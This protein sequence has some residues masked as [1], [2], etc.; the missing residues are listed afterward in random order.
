MW[1]CAS[2]H[3]WTTDVE[4]INHPTNWLFH[5]S[6]IINHPVNLH[7]VQCTS[8]CDKPRA[9]LIAGNFRVRL[10]L[11]IIINYI[12]PIIPL[13]F[14]VILYGA[15]MHDHFTSPRFAPRRLVLNDFNSI[16]LC[17]Y[18]FPSYIPLSIE[19]SNAGQDEK[20]GSIIMRNWI[21]VVVVVH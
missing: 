11:D 18:F 12:Y 2:T 3:E 4:V 20:N 13:I 16:A 17:C 9:I 6:I 15:L 5:K 8:R 21:C 10:P 7:Y 19:S 1:Y 14:L